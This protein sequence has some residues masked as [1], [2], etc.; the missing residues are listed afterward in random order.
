MKRIEELRNLALAE[1]PCPDE[2]YYRFYKALG[3]ET[4]NS[5]MTII[6]RR[7]ARLILN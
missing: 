2:F 1:G 3:A 5:P 6:L 7:T 4:E